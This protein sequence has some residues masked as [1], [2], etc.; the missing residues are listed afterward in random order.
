VITST[1][2]L[3]T[4]VHRREESLHVSRKPPSSL[5]TGG[6]ARNFGEFTFYEVG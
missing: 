2:L 6:A 1:N 3:R 5:R 4:P